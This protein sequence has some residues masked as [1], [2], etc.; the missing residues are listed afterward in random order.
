MRS[1]EIML[2]TI[3]L[4][5]SLAVYDSFQEQIKR[6]GLVLHQIAASPDLF[7]EDHCPKRRFANS[8]AGS[9]TQCF[10]TAE[11]SYRD[12][13]VSICDIPSHEL[14]RVKRYF[15]LSFECR[16]FSVVPFALSKKFRIK[17]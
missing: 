14:V 16:M 2:A 12:R 10:W 8:N 5:K 3:F 6:S 7:K 11:G 13:T 17:A 4:A 9:S 1:I 15:D